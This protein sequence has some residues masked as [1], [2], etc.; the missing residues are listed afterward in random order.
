MKKPIEEILTKFLAAQEK[1]LKPRDRADYR[2]VVELLKNYL[3]SY[4]YENLSGE[5]SRRFEKSF[6]AAGEKHRTFC[7]LFGP[8][9]IGEN[10]GMFLDYFLIRK[11]MAD[12]EFL[13]KAASI[14]SRLMLWLGGEGYIEAEASQ[15]GLARGRAAAADLPRAEKAA[16]ILYQVARASGIDVSRIPDED[17]LEFDHYTIKRL[18]A[19]K[20]WFEDITPGRSRELGPV[21]VPKAVTDLLAEGWEVSCAL[22]R[23]KGEW[24]LVEVANVYPT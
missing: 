3:N 20:L 1:S 11:V 12:A 21:K 17:Y 14:T 4:A 24:H 23:V 9:K 22:A 18:E 6:N 13:E 7:Q 19:G 2:D 5:E 10:I 8:E 16:R 15:E